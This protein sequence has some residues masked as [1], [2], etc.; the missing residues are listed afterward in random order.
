M[1]ASGFSRSTAS[2]VASVL[3]QILALQFMVSRMSHFRYSRISC[4]KG[5]ALASM[6]R[7]PSRSDCSHRVTE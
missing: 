2:R 5:T 4:L 7:P 6:S 1:T 3:R